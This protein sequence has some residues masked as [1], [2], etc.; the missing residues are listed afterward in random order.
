MPTVAYSTD[1]PL[2]VSVCHVSGPS[3][4]ACL[5]SPALD[6]AVV[7]APE[8]GGVGDLLACAHAPRSIT[9]TSGQRMVEMVPR[10]T[11]AHERSWRFGGVWASMAGL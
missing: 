7:D 1:S 11:A 9:K 8:S 6:C 4:S 2:A 3:S 10:K 5:S